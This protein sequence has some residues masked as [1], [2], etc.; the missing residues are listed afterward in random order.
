MSD[1]QSTLEQRETSYGRYRGVAE[2]S[3]AFK[4]LLEH[5]LY[6]RSK[7]LPPI[8]QESLEMIFSKLARIINGD[9]HFADSWHDIAGYA[10][11][12]VKDLNGE[13]T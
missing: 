6:K 10:S 3:Q 2:V 12:V 9:N 5:E 8:Q 7:V 1:V 13:G 4:F 11:L